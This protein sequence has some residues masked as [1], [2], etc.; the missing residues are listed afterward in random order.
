MGAIKNRIGEHYGHWTVIAHD[1]ERTKETKK[2][3][4]LCECDCGCG[5]QKS[6]RTD[7]LTQI[8]VGGCNNMVMTTSKTCERCGQEFYPKKQAKQ[9]KF[10]YDCMPEEDY[11]GAELRRRV[12]LWGLEYK[13]AKCS[14]C[15]YDKCVAALDFHHTNMDEKEFNLSSRNLKFDWEKIKEELDKCVVVCANCHRELHYNQGE[16]EYET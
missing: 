12:K 3:Y 13:G 16:E 2:Q 9:R 15:G 1:D 11:T 10:C 4:W 14:I 5:T 6:I 7:A 8:K